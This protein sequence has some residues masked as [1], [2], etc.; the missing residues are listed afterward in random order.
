MWPI[1]LKLGPITLNTYGLMIA[2]GF[3]TALHFIQK[4]CA[5]Q[6]ISAEVMN[7]AAFWSL[8]LGIAGTRALHIFMFPSE[9]SWSDPIGWIA[10]WRGGLVF[11]GGP[12]VAAMFLF[13]F[14]R[15]HGVSFLKVIDIAGVYLPLAHAIGRMGCFFKGCCYGKLT[16]VPWGLSFPRWPKDISQTPT[17]S[18]AY[19]DQ[20]RE[21]LIQATDTHALAVHPTQ[22]YEAAF[23]VGICISLYFIRKKWHLFDG[24]VLPAYLALY[25]V[26]RFIVEFYRGDNNPTVFNGLISEQQAFSL[27]S[28]PIAVILFIVLYLYSKRQKSATA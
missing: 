11:Q 27:L 1:L 4:E 3:L 24:I 10:I 13:V 28:L 12:P 7:T 23:L 19:L 5:K 18:P 17:D 16:T 9:Y 26:A 20:L 6:N 21:G 8:L 22:F 2:I 15:K 25:G 14:L